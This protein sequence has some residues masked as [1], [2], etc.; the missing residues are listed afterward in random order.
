MYCVVDSLKCSQQPFVQEEVDLNYCSVHSSISPYK[1]DFSVKNFCN[2]IVPCACL[3]DDVHVVVVHV[4]C[5]SNSFVRRCVILIDHQNSAVK[6]VRTD[7]SD[8]G[9]PGEILGSLF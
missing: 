6:Y 7:V 2:G 1:Y 5:M 8:T 4:S 3:R 9:N